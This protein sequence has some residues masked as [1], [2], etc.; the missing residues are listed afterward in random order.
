MAPFG[1][2]ERIDC[3]PLLGFFLHVCLNSG[4]R[5]EYCR[6]DGNSSNDERETAIET[7]NEDGSSK[8]VFLLSTRAGGLGINLATADTVVLYDSDWNPQVGTRRL[9]GHLSTYFASSHLTP[10]PSSPHFTSPLSTMRI[11][12]SLECMVLL[13]CCCNCGR[14]TC[15]PKTARTESARRSL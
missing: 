11:F 14:W 5:Y 2:C 4:S 1:A 9:L 3:L 7:F 8:F 13:V 12:V 15:K 10:P 6:I